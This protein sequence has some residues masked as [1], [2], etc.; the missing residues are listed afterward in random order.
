MLKRLI[1]RANADTVYD[2]LFHEG[3][4]IIRGNNS[5]GKSTILDFIF[6]VLGGEVVVWKSAAALCTEVFAE[7]DI[8]GAI[9]TLHRVRRDQPKTPLSIF[10][11]P[12]TEALNHKVEGWK[13]HPYSPAR[14]NETFTTVLFRLLGFPEV[15]ADN[16]GNITIHQALR[17]SY[18]DQISRTT[19]LMR[20]EDW[21]S[22]M[23]RKVVADLLFGV[24]DNELYDL[25]IHARLLEQ[26]LKDI[27]EQIKYNTDLLD[28]V[29]DG[30]D[31]VKLLK[32]NEELVEELEKINLAIEEAATQ[33]KAI[34]NTA[35]AE[36]NKLRTK[37][38]FEKEEVAKIDDYIEGLKLE[39]KDSEFFISNLERKLRAIEESLATR[40]AFGNLPT[41]PLCNVEVKHIK[42]EVACEFSGKKIPGDFGLTSMVKMKEELSFQIKES[43][44]LQGRRQKHFEEILARRSELASDYEIDARTYQQRVRSVKSARDNRLD[45]LYLE[46]GRLEAEFKY[47]RQLLEY[48]EVLR[49]SKVREG[50][51]KES[52]YQ[53]KLKISAR[54]S[55]QHG[56]IHQSAQL[57][58][59]HAREILTKDLERQDEFQHINSIEL[60]FEKNIYF[61]NGKH[62]FSASSNAILKNAIIFG[63]LFSSCEDDEFR[64]PRFLLCDNIE[65]AG[66]EEERSKTFQRVV[67]DKAVS[68]KRPFQI[69]YTTSMIEENLDQPEYTIGEYYTKT[70]KTLKLSPELQKA[71]VENSGIIEGGELV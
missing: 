38:L 8:N 55:Q 67:C 62:N 17:L 20:E 35:D 44:R 54:Q 34:K 29:G 43:T 11:G 50:E 42:G 36:L 24:Y 52:I 66:M 49:K 14:D 48:V 23:K 31:A 4:N 28:A 27:T 69:I 6:H 12:L 68:A 25:Q 9:I 64:Y 22:P 41:C 40:K 51:L 47:L 58:K 37:V 46:K 39:M 15:K 26:E 5:S 65:D 56:R 16:E 70:N 45:S 63:V 53:V 59:N 57:I 18:I 60:S 3:V 33:E 1:V 71:A 10:M 7:V 30:L 21:D 2:Q 61:L 13:T 32:R 19:S